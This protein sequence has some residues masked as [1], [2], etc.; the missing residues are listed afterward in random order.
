MSRLRNN[1][2]GVSHNHVHPPKDDLVGRKHDVLDTDHPFYD[3]IMGMLDRRCEYSYHSQGGV[4]SLQH[5]YVSFL[6]LR[7]DSHVYDPT[8]GLE[9]K[10]KPWVSNTYFQTMIRWDGTYIPALRYENTSGDQAVAISLAAKMGFVLV[11]KFRNRIDLDV[12]Y[13]LISIPI[14]FQINHQF[15][16]FQ[17]YASSNKRNSMIVVAGRGEEDRAATIYAAVRHTH[18]HTY[19]ASSLT[20]SLTGSV[21]CCPAPP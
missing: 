13:V 10:L 8:I 19:I 9:R 3:D 12:S 17:I 11:A 15:R 4:H 7:T 18:T 14:F 21:S 16:R 5:P 20:I 6:Q 1:T 2:M